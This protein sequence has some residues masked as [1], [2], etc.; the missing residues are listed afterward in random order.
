MRLSKI[1][2]FAILVVLILYDPI[3]IMISLAIIKWFQFETS[4]KT[5]NSPDKIIDKIRDSSEENELEDEANKEVSSF[6][7]KLLDLHRPKIKSDEGLK[8]G[9]ELI[10]GESPKQG[11]VYIYAKLFSPLRLSFRKKIWL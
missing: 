5:Y 4:K 3:S 8:C 10:Q 1:L 9:D 6:E 11:I 7:T 2:I